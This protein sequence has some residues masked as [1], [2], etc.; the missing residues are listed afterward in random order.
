MTLSLP[1]RADESTP[2]CPWLPEKVCHPKRFSLEPFWVPP[3]LE[4]AVTASDA[5]L[6]DAPAVPVTLASLRPKRLSVE[7][8]PPNLA[9]VCVSPPCALITSCTLLV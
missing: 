5:T 2:L 9:P 7:A 8:F 6:P 3:F 4:P 1:V